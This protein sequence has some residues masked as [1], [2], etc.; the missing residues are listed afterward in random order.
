MAY[1]DLVTNLE[2]IQALYR[3]F[4]ERDIPSILGIVDPQV[5]IQQTPVLPWGGEFKGWQGLDQFM[6]GLIHHIRSAVEI[7]ELIDAAESIV[8]LGYTRG[9]VNRNGAPF[10]I[11]IAHVWTLREGKV[12]R[13]Q[14]YIQT[15]GMLAILAL[16]PT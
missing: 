8:A 2:V 16:P 5:E 6:D 1:P 10:E 13:F 15:P 11:R 3:A 9:T 7:T 14:P 4:A 12:L